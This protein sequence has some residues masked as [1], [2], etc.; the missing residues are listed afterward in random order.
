MA[1]TTAS[2]ALSSYPWL[3]LLNAACLVFSPLLSQVI[4]L[5][6]HVL[7]RLIYPLPGLGSPNPPFPALYDLYIVSL[8]FSPLPK[9]ACNRLNSYHL[10]PCVIP[11]ILS[12]VSFAFVVF[13]STIINFLFFLWE[14]ATK[15]RF[16]RDRSSLTHKC[17]E[18]D[19]SIG[20][21]KKFFCV[22]P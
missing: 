11:L 14:M 3:L 20:L 6:A 4:F 9:A 12:L 16:R 19:P 15:A 8:P 1:L 21:A 18:R 10:F 13:I 17:R 22:F 5:R 2:R 7:T